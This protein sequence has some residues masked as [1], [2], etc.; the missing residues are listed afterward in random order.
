[1]TTQPLSHMERLEQVD[2]EFYRALSALRQ[3]IGAPGAL[4]AKTK[5]LISL[6]MDAAGSHRDGVK[7]LARRA[8]SLGATDQEIM[9]V[10]RL[11]YSNAGTPGL[12]AGLAA[13]ED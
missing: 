2:P 8:R 5:T 13:F 9:E 10:V 1:M 4:D 3:F 7:N 6:A 11:A 12:V